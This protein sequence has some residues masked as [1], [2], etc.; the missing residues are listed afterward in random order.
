[1]PGRYAPQAAIAA[2]HCKAQRAADTDWRPIVRF[3][4][5]LERLEPSPVVSLNRPV[6]VAIADRPQA[7]LDIIVILPASG[8]LDISYRK[9]RPA[10]KPFA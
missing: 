1:L 9:L 3:Y 8:A 2:E 5:D 6:A 4:D 7:G 10:R